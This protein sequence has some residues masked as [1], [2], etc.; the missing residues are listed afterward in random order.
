[1]RLTVQ[2]RSVS[3]KLNDRWTAITI[4]GI[5]FPKSNCFEWRAKQLYKYIEIRTRPCRS[6][7]L[8]HGRF[9]VVPLEESQLKFACVAN[10]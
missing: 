8:L 1:M 7:T 2:E 5:C 3:A 9:F 4:N 10:P 6:I